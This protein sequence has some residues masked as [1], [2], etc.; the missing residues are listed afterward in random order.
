[1]FSILEQ[2]YDFVRRESFE[3]I[4]AIPDFL[5]PRLGADLRRTSVPFLTACDASPVL[6]FG[7]SFMKFK[8]SVAA[9]VGSSAERRGDFVKF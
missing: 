6:G 5:M 8:Q 4:V 1:M 7:V 2:V 3:E 9:Q